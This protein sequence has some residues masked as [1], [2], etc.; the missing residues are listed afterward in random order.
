MLRRSNKSGIIFQ[1]VV[2]KRHMDHTRGLMLVSAFIIHCITLPL[3]SNTKQAQNLLVARSSLR[4]SWFIPSSEP[5]KKCWE[6]MTTL[7][8][9]HQLEIS[10]PNSSRAFV[11]EYVCFFWLEHPLDL[12]LPSRKCS[13]KP[14][15]FH[16]KCGWLMHTLSNTLL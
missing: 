10:R 2:E 15:S 8:Q 3:P 14:S 4:L 16:Q 9:L 7:E 6:W 11:F 12:Q 13:P 1:Y 5:C